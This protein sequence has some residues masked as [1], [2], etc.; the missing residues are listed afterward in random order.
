MATG[1]SGCCVWQGHGGEQARG[2]GGGKAGAK[3]VRGERS[4]NS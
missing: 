1:I 3:K 4:A 2:R